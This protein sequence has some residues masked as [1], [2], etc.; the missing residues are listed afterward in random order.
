MKKN[1]LV[2]LADEKYVEQAKQLFSS[3]H[4]NGGWDGDY[5]LLAY[6]I[7]EKKLKDFRDKG[8]LIKKCRPLIEISRDKRDLVMMMKYY[9]FTYCFK[10]WKKIVFMDSDI[11]IVSSIKNL[12][13]VKIISAAFDFSHKIKNQFKKT[14]NHEIIEGLKNKYD[15]NS[16]AF[17]AGL[18]A[19]D[20]VIIEKDTFKKLKELSK[21]YISH[22]IMR[23]QA[24]LNLYFYNKWASLNRVYNFN[25]IEIMTPFKKQSINIGIIWHFMGVKKPWNMDKNN[26][27]YIN[28]KK[29]FD[30]FEKTT[31]KIPASRV[32]QLSLI[33]IKTQSQIIEKEY[34]HFAPHRFIDRNIGR[35]GFIL[36]KISPKTYN[37]IKVIMPN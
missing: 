26:F 21:K 36:K 23:E 14:R 2:T 25:P 31:F 33:E 34:E 1:L 8:I 29:N 15:F 7:P 28:W 30:K 5:M 24:I 4:N 16:P 18:F 37:K 11:I 35:I 3:A 22:S 13:E 19:F 32:K 10:K 12:K 20:S 6:K 27:F 9:I 17:N